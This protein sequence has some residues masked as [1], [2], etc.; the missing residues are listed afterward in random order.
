[1]PMKIP[2]EL[3]PQF[4]GFH[5]GVQQ[6]V[7]RV[8]REIVKPGAGGGQ[9]GIMESIFFPKGGKID[10]VVGADIKKMF[11]TMFRNM[12]GTMRQWGSRMQREMKKSMPLQNFEKAAKK[13]GK[14]MH[15]AFRGVRG[16]MKVFGAEMTGLVKLIDRNTRSLQKMA[17]AGAGIIGGGARM[18][19]RGVSSGARMIGRG[20]GRVGS[21]AARGA[22]FA[23]MLGAGGLAGFATGAFRESIGAYEQRANARL[24]AAPY[25]MG[26]QGQRPDMASGARYGYNAAAAAGIQS[27]AAR[28]GMGTGRYAGQFAM[29]MNRAWGPEMMSMAAG[30]QRRRGTQIDTLKQ[31]KTAQREITRIFGAAVESGLKSSRMVEFTQAATDFAEKQLSVTP[32]KDSMRDYVKQLAFVQARGGAGMMGRYGDQAMGRIDQA[33]KGA[34][35]PQEAFLNRAFGFGRGA[36]Y[37]D[38]TRRRE[39][40]I[41][42][43]QN[44]PAIMKQLQKEYGKGQFGGLSA[45]GLFAFKGMGFGSTSMAQKFGEMYL[46][47]KVKGLTS[48]QEAKKIEQIMSGEADRKLAPIQRRAYKAMSS[49]GHVAQSLA[50]R[51]DEFASLGKQWYKVKSELNKAAV[52]MAKG[53]APVLKGVMVPIA[54]SITSLTKTFGPRLAALL[55]KGIRALER[56]SAGVTAFFQGYSQSKSYMIGALRDAMKAASRASSEVGRQQKERDEANITGSLTVGVNAARLRRLRQMRDRMSVADRERLMQLGYAHQAAKGGSQVDE[57]GRSKFIQDLNRLAEKYLGRGNRRDN[58]KNP[59][60]NPRKAVQGN[61]TKS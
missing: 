59:A 57:E 12:S 7:R 2:F 37:L 14:S 49:F 16:T 44:L 17:R 5:T 60:L 42:N 18:L 36:S 48:E 61:P 19:G 20:L 23:G 26:D 53:V 35:G 22:A 50:K 24:Q 4:D 55:T 15:T 43:A 8:R 46:G 56:M 39:A 9:G 51:F 32:D 41:G 30:V 38:V 3:D 27:Q 11:G 45:A 31:L 10:R 33:I 40:G 21:F 13:M 29:E 28:Q 54:K 6:M 25:L 52:N 47:G 34:G 1:M 58:T